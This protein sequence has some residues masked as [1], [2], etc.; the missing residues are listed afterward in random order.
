MRKYLLIIFS[1]FFLFSSYS[2]S[3]ADSLKDL[4]SGQKG[5]TEGV[6]SVEAAINN[7]QEVNV[8]TIPNQ[9]DNAVGGINFVLLRVISLI[10]MVSGIS[11]VLII[12]WAGFNYVTNL[13]DEAK[14]KKTHKIIVNA[15]IGLIAIFISYAVVENTIRLLYNQ[16]QKQDY[17]KIQDLDKK[18]LIP[19]S[20]PN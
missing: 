1:F 18:K 12:I 11:A 17:Q 9:S 6:G 10:L 8:P 5:N 14:I 2:I 4:L 20:K 15:V 16:T 3:Q 7:N 19:N 13:G